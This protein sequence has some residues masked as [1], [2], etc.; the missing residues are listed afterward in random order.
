[1]R[2]IDTKEFQANQKKYF[3]LASKERIIIKRGKNSSIT[4]VPTSDEELI[5]TPYLKTKI[6]KTRKERKHGNII[7]L[8]THEEIDN[9][10]DSL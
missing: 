4:L 6:D 8:S 2:I 10:F 1:M 9:Y 5:I 3:D 7:T